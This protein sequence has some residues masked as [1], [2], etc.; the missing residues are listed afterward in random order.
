MS[1]PKLVPKT[2]PK[3]A[4]RR[5]RPPKASASSPDGGILDAA[6][7]TAVQTAL[8]TLR[9]SHADLAIALET[10][11]QGSV[12][13]SLTTTIAALKTRTARIKAEAERACDA[14]GKLGA[15]KHRRCQSVRHMQVQHGVYRAAR[16]PDPMNTII[17]SVVLILLEGCITAAML[18]SDGRVEPMAGLAYGLMFALVNILLGLV[19]GFFGLRYLGYGLSGMLADDPKAI[20]IRKLASIGLVAAA[21]ALSQLLFAAMRLRAVGS[22]HDVYSFGE[23]G[24]WSSW[25]DGVSI[26]ILTIGVISGLLSCWKGYVGLA[27]PVPGY[28]EVW[29]EATDGIDALA[30][31]IADDALTAIED[32]YEDAADEAEDALEDA[33]DQ[34]IEHREALADYA[35]DVADHNNDIDAAK[36]SLTIE[37]DMIARR[38]GYVRGDKNK[39]ASPHALDFTAFDALRVEPPNK[40]GGASGGGD[41]TDIDTLKTLLSDLNETHD[42]AAA[43]IRAALAAYRADAPD[44][45]ILM[46]EGDAS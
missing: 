18:V 5:G 30:D 32:I 24:F 16:I 35:R 9:A 44:L 22:H 20:R 34:P 25:N 37:A 39:P 8:T 19:A 45:G 14:I 15:E 6:L 46:D 7:Q 33:Q 17:L 23:V 11:W 2:A 26:I 43:D 29:I 12:S 38:S 4:K 40:G 41:S 1:I 10:L 31:D 13:V 36:A 3:T 42:R 28:G 27:D 21:I